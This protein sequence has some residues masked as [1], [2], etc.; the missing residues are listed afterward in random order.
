MRHGLSVPILAVAVF[1]CIAV[2]S[3]PPDQVALA[4]EPDVA[5]RDGDLSMSGPGEPEDVRA[6]WVVDNFEDGNID[7]WI[8]EGG[9]QCSASTS[10]STA[11]GAYSMRID[12][13]CGHLLGRVLDI[14]SSQ[15][16]GV[17]VWV[18]SNTVDTYDT[19]LVFGDQNSGPGENYGAIYF[20]G[21]NSGHWA[22]FNGASYSCGSRNPDQWYRVQFTVDWACKMYD[23][24]ID[25][26]FQQRNVAFYHQPTASFERIHVYNWDSATARYDEISFSTP[27]VGPPIFEDDFERTSACRWSSATP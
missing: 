8:D 7:D 10:A 20:Q 22:V 6:A 11:S 17:T 5:N 12:G 18:R 1:F 15:P 14:P 13:A 24:R 16:T 23:V 25:G 21:M 19:Y 2:L 3:I 27:S 4:A 26:A 9:S